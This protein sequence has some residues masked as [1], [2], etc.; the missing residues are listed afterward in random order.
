MIK[1]CIVHYNTPKMT[2]CLIKSINKFTPDCLIYVFDN[3]DKQPFTYRQPNITI[4]DNTKNQIID[5]DK[6]LEK[7]PARLSNISKQNNYASFRHCI[8]VD[9]CFDLI[10][11]NFILLDSDVL[12]K[13]DISYI[14]DDDF[15]FCGDIQYNAPTADGRNSKPRVIPYCCF[16]N[17]NRCKELSIRYFNENY[18]R[19][20]VEQATDNNLYDTGA[21]F[22][23][24]TS[25]YTY[26]TINIE[27]FIVH[28][29]SASF[30]GHTTQ[31]NIDS[32]LDKYKYLYDKYTN[33][34]L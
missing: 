14:F 12:I 8:S 30:I 7:Y 11:D 9:K 32:W 19:G 26:K 25:K 13:R 2:E 17:V 24:A 23:E 29:R 10:N 27:Q 33:C 16:I 3:S 18:M 6:L 28:F 4:F 20:I 15:I 1:F 34:T 21:W 22:Y 31:E 5:F